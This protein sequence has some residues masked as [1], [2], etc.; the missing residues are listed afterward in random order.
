LL[1][2]WLKG[3][4]LAHLQVVELGKKLLSGQHEQLSNSELL[5]LMSLLHSSRATRAFV[6]GLMLAGL[7]GQTEP[8]TATAEPSNPHPVAEPNDGREQTAAE[9]SIPNEREDEPD[10]VA[11]ASALDILPLEIGYELVGLVDGAAENDS[12]PERVAALRREI[13]QELGIITPHVHICDNLDL[14]PGGYRILLNDSPIGQGE[15]RAGKMLAIAPSDDAPAIEGKETTDPTFGVPARWIDT[16]EDHHAEAL[17]YTVVDHPTIIATHLGERVRNHA[18]VLLGRQELHHLLD[19]LAERYPRLVEVVPEIVPI[20]TLLKVLRNLLRARISIR[21]LRSIL[22]ALADLVDQADDAE[23][24]TEWVR[25]RLALQITSATKGE[26]GSVAAITLMPELEETLRESFSA[27]AAGTDGALEPEVLQALFKSAEGY[28]GRFAALGA[29]PLIITPPDLR[30]YVFAIFEHKVPQ[31]SVVSFR[32]ISP[33]VPLKVVSTLGLPT[34][35]KPAPTEGD[36][37]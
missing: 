1:S 28:L 4:K 25:A 35:K 2:D 6:G 27:I 10:R 7:R 23:Q 30:R 14:A 36:P 22:E 33:N 29:A 24:L 34:P 12:L 13:A 9:R 19:L 3:A 15:C 26:D 17:G 18:P 21:D 8:P 16:G 32:E 5:L 31:Y 37:E 11:G 20:G